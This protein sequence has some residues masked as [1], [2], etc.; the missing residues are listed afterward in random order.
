M[1]WIDETWL[2]GAFNAMQD[3]LKVDDRTRNEMIQF[4]LDEGFWKAETLK[5]HDAQIARWNACLNP[6]KSEFFKVGEVWALMARFGRHDLFL[7]MADDL[8][9]E[10]RA[11]P[12][13]ER[14]QRAL[15]RIADAVEACQIECA[16]ARSALDR[17]G[18]PQPGA[19]RGPVGHFSQPDEP[20]L[21]SVPATAVERIGCP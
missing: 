17:M 8:G 11:I 19:R 5:T 20:S 15:D 14:Q 18:L 10:V 4:L 12:T 2:R 7:R 3:T 16:N 21:G 6:N 9:Y 13:P 1:A